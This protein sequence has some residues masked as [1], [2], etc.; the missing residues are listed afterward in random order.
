MMVENTENPGQEAQ[1]GGEYTAANIKVLEGL[2]AVRMRPGMYIGD[3]HE[4]GLHHLVYEVV[5]N[6]IDEALAGHC[7]KVVVVVHVDGSVSVEDNGRGIPTGIHPDEG[8]PT[9]QVVLTKLHAGGKFDNDSYKVS[10]GLHGV[11]VSVVNALSEALRCEV[12]QEGRYFAQDY[13]RGDPV[14]EFKAVGKTR[15]RGTKITFTPDKEV[16][17]TVDFSFD[18]LSQRLRE[19]AFLNKGITIDIRDERDDRSHIFMY[20]GGIVSFV[21]HLV[22]NKQPLHDDPIFLEG[23]KDGVSCEIAVQWSTAYSETIFSFANNINTHFGGTHLSGY[24]AALTRTVN[25]WATKE[26]LLKKLKEN[27]SGDD[28]R[29]GS[30]CIISV[31]IPEPQFEGQTKQKLG[32]SNVKGIVESIV[33]EQLGFYL[34]ENPAVGKT[35]IEKAVE[36][37]RAREAAR[38]ARDLARRK[39]VLDGGGLPGKLADCQEKDPSQCEIYLVEGDSAGGSAKSARDRKFQAILPLRGK[40]LNVEKARF[41]RMLASEEI[42]T[43]IT[44]LGTGIGPGEFDLGKLRYHRVIIMTDADV[45]GAHIR[46]LLLTFFFRQMQTLVTGGH[47]YIAQPPLYKA[48]KGRKVVYLKD[49]KALTDYLFEEGAKDLQVQ[50]AGRESAIVGP[51]MLGFL[52]AIRTFGGVLDKASRQRDLRVLHAFVKSFDGDR[53]Q[54]HD[55]ARMGQTVAAT[56]ALLEE[57]YR[58]DELRLTQLELQHSEDF[59]AW[60]ILARTRQ[61]GVDRFTH[62]GWD[63]VTSGE[64]KELIRLHRKVGEF[65]HAPYTLVRPRGE[66]LVFRTARELYAHVEADSRKGYDI[67]RYKG[68]GEMN[69]DQLW[70]TT[71]DP[72][73]RTLVQVKLDDVAEAEEIFSILMGDAVDRRRAFIEDNA[74]KVRNLDV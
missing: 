26:G 64:M 13:V 49:D 53:E 28:I 41:D 5:D 17:E 30:V 31:K 63:F 65:G 11:G 21:E 72:D 71:M 59:D 39:S 50:A 19:M 18:I 37:S 29:E 3:T 56:R 25:S 52:E 6:A 35:I 58:P 32:N 34:E 4:T 2:E 12:F 73:A 47:L 46:T 62:L 7:D 42:V 55:E 48:K 27:L 54:L 36:S 33:N 16:F 1:G 45:D 9:P 38:K 51:E 8:V 20:E 61:G 44:A 24:K 15:K 43:M 57:L 67:Q 10:G 70:D 22:A 14:T 68:L 69:P 23:E 60:E 74:L 66:P 40:I